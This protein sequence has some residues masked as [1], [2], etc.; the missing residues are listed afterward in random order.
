VPSRP[1]ANSVKVAGSGTA[2][3]PFG[4]PT[5]IF[6]DGGSSSENHAV[7]PAAAIAGPKFTVP[8][9]SFA[10]MFVNVTPGPA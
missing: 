4:G 7:P 6:T 3:P 8:D 9:R 1:L 5:M 2:A 10:A